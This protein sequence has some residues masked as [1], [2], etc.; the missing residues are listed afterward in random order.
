MGDD[1]V[2]SDLRLVAGSTADRP[3]SDAG[4]LERWGDDGEANTRSLDTVCYDPGMRS[5]REA[6]E[7]DR[8]D[9]CGRKAWLLRFDYR[10]AW[11]DVIDV[12]LCPLCAGKE[13]GA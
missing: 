9:S 10:A 7:M 1:I 2:A 12:W 11:G 6:I 13:E 3:R 8:C 5:D 4:H